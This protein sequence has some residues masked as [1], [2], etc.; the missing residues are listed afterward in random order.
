MLVEDN[1]FSLISEDEGV[2]DDFATREEERTT[3]EQGALILEGLEGDGE[4]EC[5]GDDSSVLSIPGSVLL[6]SDLTIRADVL[7]HEDGTG[8]NRLS[9]RSRFPGWLLL[10]VLLLIAISSCALRSRTVWKNEALRLEAKLISQRKLA[11]LSTASILKERK[12]LSERLE[13]CNAERAERSS[14]DNSDDNKAFVSDGKDD[15]FLK[16]KN[17]YFEASV[18]LGHCSRQW[19]KWWQDENNESQGGDGGENSFDD[20][21]SFTFAMSKLMDR[22]SRGVKEGTNNLI[23]TSAQSLGHF[24]ETLADLDHLW[25]WQLAD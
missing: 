18:S 13:R 24:R 5:K 1:S 19:Q 16:L 2:A 21:D 11:L 15:A 7:R 22:V 6:P 10:P 12:G 14:F 23:D 4:G 8:T 9:L 20:D 25:S 3:Q 17:C